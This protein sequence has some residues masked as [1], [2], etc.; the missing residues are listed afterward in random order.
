MNA[1]HNSDYY[2]NPNVP[3]LNEKE[4][5]NPNQFVYKA[6]KIIKQKRESAG[7]FLT[8]RLLE[9]VRKYRGP[10]ATAQYI[11]S[12]VK[13]SSM[14]VSNMIGPLERMSLANHP[15]KGFYFMV[16][17]VPQSKKV[18]DFGEAR[19]AP[20]VVLTPGLLKTL[21]SLSTNTSKH[22]QQQ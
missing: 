20:N 17:G 3:E 21:L 1:T 11:R 9:T 14:T 12:T 10:E 2:Q 18:L 15:V 16:V 6:Q 4:C 13:N 22:S 7:V 8:G 19:D 5:P